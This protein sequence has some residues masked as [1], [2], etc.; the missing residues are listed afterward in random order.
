MTNISLSKEHKR[1][2]KFAV[3]GI[4]G[5][6]V[7]FGFFN[8]F[9]FIFNLFSE[10][11]STNVDFVLLSSMF[12]FVI[13][14]FNNYFWNRNWTYPESKQFSHSD[15]F[16]KFGVVSII[17]LIIRTPLFAVI[18]GPIIDYSKNIIPSN[19]FISPDTVGKNIAL[20][21]VV[22]IVL[23]WNYFVNRFWTY[24]HIK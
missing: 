19:F 14:V 16:F 21:I 3:V 10:K 13:A 18:K 8:F 6:V 5:T 4:S 2:V 15:Q 1:F 23:F 12:S 11:F 20:A 7:D 24:R 22:I 17:G 9:T